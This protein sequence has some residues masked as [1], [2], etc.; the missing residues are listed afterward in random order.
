M[1]LASFSMVTLTNT[2]LNKLSLMTVVDTAPVEQPNEAFDPSCDLVQFSALACLAGP[3]S[4]PPTAEKC[5]WQAL[6]GQF[7]AVPAGC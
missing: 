5:V 3:V 7:A 6:D 2:M 1:L 4:G